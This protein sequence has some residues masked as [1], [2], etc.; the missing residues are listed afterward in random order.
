MGKHARRQRLCDEHMGPTVWN[1]GRRERKE[2]ER[3]ALVWPELKRM[4]L[5]P[6]R[7]LR[8][9]GMLST[10]PPPPVLGWSS[11]MAAPPFTLQGMARCHVK[12]RN[13]DKV[14]S[15][16]RKQTHLIVV[17]RQDESPFAMY[18]AT[19]CAVPRPCTVMV[20]VPPLPVSTSQF[21]TGIL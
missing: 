6:E 2:I 3:H 10:T 5:E 17:L 9:T 20:T 1:R 18:R 16:R 19:H 4:V 14:R 11:E 7:R 8:C 12:P 21:L 13:T 15:H